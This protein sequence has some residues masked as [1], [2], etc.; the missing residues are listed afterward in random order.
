M[1]TRLPDKQLPLFGI[2]IIPDIGIF[3]NNIYR[4]LKV[5]LEHW[6]MVPFQNLLRD[7]KQYSQVLDLKRNQ[8][9]ICVTFREKERRAKKNLLH[10]PMIHFC[11]SQQNRLSYSFN[12]SG[13]FC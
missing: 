5:T 6:T 13:L 3:Q 9:T 12:F 11:D 4:R 1:V 7:Q 2:A 8:C 10:P